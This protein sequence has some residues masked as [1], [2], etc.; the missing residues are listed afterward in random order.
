MQVRPFFPAIIWAIVIL[1]LST[2]AG[3]QLPETILA[4]DKLGHFFAY[5]T[6]TWLIMNGLDRV[7]VAEWKKFLWSAGLPSVYG[8]LLEFVQWAFF[9]HRY[10]E[11]WDLI[12]N[13]T[14]AFAAWLLQQYFITKI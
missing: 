2:N 3:I 4:P 13:I 7:K 11:V 1:V 14:G 10:F 8:I 5:G 6:L 9:P 12:A